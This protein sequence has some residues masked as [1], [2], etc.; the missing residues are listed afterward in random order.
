MVLEENVLDVDTYL[1]LRGKSLKWKT[2]LTKRT[3]WKSIGKQFIYS[4]C[5]WK[6][7]TGRNGK[8][9]GRW[10]SYMLCTGFDCSTGISGK[11]YRIQTITKYKRICLE[12]KI[13]GTE[14]MFDLMCAKGREHFY[15]KMWIYRKTNG[16]IRSWNDS[17]PVIPRL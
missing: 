17:I 11:W 5:I 7:Q 14:M 10:S 15:E 3:G 2:H 6:W 8:S 12:L 9:R 4:C 13:P 1:M 16:Q